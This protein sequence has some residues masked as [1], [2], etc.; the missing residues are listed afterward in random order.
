M[1]IP[2][3]STVERKR[4]ELMP[5]RCAQAEKLWQG[6]LSQSENS[7]EQRMGLPIFWAICEAARQL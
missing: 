5:Q 1:F 2:W 7:S 6:F 4:F 3:L